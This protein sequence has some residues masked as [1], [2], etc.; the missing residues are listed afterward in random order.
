MGNGNNLTLNVSED[1]VNFKRWSQQTWLQ[2][3]ESIMVSKDQAI[4]GV[5]CLV[6]VVVAVFYVVTL[7]VPDW[8]NIIGISLDPAAVQFWLIA[9]PVLIGFVA[10]LAIGAWIGWTMATTPPPKPIEE[11]TSEMEEKKEEPKVEEPKAEEPAAPAA[12]TM[13]EEKKLEKKKKS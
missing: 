13:T 7:F 12:E 3:G 1:T 5:I 6:C 2:S 10:I 8:G 11:I 9:V 4:G